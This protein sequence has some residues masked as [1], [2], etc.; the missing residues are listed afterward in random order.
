MTRVSRRAQASAG[1]FAVALLSGCGTTVPAS[2]VAASTEG[3]GSNGLSATAGPGASS[4]GPSSGVAPASAGQPGPAG[5]PAD[6]SGGFAAGGSTS[7]GSVP[8][9]GATIGPGVSATTINIG[10]T[11]TDN[12][13]AAAQ[14]LG[15]SGAGVGGG[16]LEAQYRIVLDDINAHGGV[17]GRKLHPI[18]YH[19]DATST[20][21]TDQ[22]ESA[23]CSAW[24]QDTKVLAVAA[25]EASQSYTLVRCLQKAGVIHVATG[26]TASDESTYGQFPGFVEIASLDIDRMAAVW[27]SRL[28]TQGYFGGWDYRTGNASAATPVKIGIISFDDAAS[29]RAVTSYLEPSLKALGY[30]DF[31]YERVLFP[32]G[33]ADNGTTISQIQNV[34][35]KFR[36]EGVSHVLPVESQGA[37]VGG[38]FARGASGQRYYPRFGLTSGNGAQVLIGA[39]VWPTDELAG[40]M[41]YGW[42]PLADVNYSDDPASGPDSNSSRQ[43]CVKLM[44]AHGQTVSDTITERQVV[45]TCDQLYFLA[46]LLNRAG[47]PNREAFLSAVNGIGGGF[48]AGETF[49]TNFA[50]GQHDG[51]A[52]GRPF[53]YVASCTC[54][55][56]AGGR[57]R[58]P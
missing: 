8:V 29:T 15:A 22:Q 20:D 47:A 9:Q 41:G 40:S 26:F 32:K 35:L 14:A 58:I 19:Y 12:S 49:S 53:G 34:V 55:R 50:S 38:F 7:S 45:E 18:I 33:E 46:D 2:S 28:Q 23:A 24:T 48:A 37:G 57:F 51:V 10:L 5:A 6:G 3:A 44:K 13:K 25:G 52:A 56:Y 42:T 1:V 39:G 17:L 54:F 27:P 30:K 11:V 36:S 31:T 21:S 43:H 4:A 16:D